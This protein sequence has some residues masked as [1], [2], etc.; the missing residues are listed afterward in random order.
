MFNGISAREDFNNAVRIFDNVF[1][2]RIGANENVVDK[3]KLTQSA[4]R[5]E[6]PLAANATSYA[7]PIMNNQLSANGTIFNTEIR[8]NPQDTLVP[9]HVGVFLALPTSATDA[10]FRLVGYPNQSVF[11]NAVQMRALYNG[12]LSIAVNNYKYTYGWDLQ[13]HWVS[14]QTQQTAAFGAGSPEDQDD[15]SSDGFY[16]MQ[17]FVLFGGSQNVQVNI[18]LPIAPTAVDAFSRYVVIFRGVL[19]QNSTPTS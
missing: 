5:L 13:R 7:F 11:A 3:F 9:T 8:L 2:D 17:P 19:A 6:Q 16:P 12:Q 10:A 15:F 14:N 1:R 4:I 18:N